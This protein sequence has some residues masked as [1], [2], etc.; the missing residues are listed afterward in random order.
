MVADDSL[1]CRN[2]YLSRLGKQTVQR[3][4]SSEKDKHQERENKWRNARIA[5]YYRHA[6]IR[7]GVILINIYE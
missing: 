4:R 2:N 7:F 1:G 3:R 6:I 5:V